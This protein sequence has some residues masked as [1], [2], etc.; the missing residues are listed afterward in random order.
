MVE[1]IAAFTCDQV[2]LDAGETKLERLGAWACRQRCSNP[3]NFASLTC[4]FSFCIQASVCH[5]RSRARPHAV[6]QH[7]ADFPAIVYSRVLISG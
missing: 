4:P 7:A 3:Q 6:Q 5:D 2:Y 1:G